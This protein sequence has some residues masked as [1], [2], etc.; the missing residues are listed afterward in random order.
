MLALK[1]EYKVLALARSGSE[2]SLA[3]LNGL[4]SRFRTLV[5]RRG[6]ASEV[7]AILA[8]MPPLLQV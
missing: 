3:E 5:K 8:Q 7:A 2:A 4:C 6:M 1:E